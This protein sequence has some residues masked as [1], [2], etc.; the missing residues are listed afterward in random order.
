MKPME[1]APRVRCPQCGA[2]LTIQDAYSY[3]GQLRLTLITRSNE[4]KT[5]NPAPAFWI[6]HA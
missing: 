5:L 1:I 6:L 2:P 4:G 3:W